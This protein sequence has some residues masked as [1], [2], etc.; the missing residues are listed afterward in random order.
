MYIGKI[1]GTK[2]KLN[3]LF[4]CLMLFMFIFGMAIDSILIFV[5][6][7]VH[8]LGHVIVA[9]KMKYQ[10]E[11]IELLPIGGVATISDA[12]YK[13]A[14]DEWF[15]AWAGPFNNLLF[16]VILT[17]YKESTPYSDILIQ[18]NLTLFFFNLLPALPL[19]GGRIIKATLS[20]NRS[21]VEANKIAALFG[22]FIGL[23]MIGLS[24]YY[25]M[26][27]LNSPVYLFIL[28]LFLSISAFKEYKNSTYLPVRIGFA[29]ATNNNR[30]IEGKLVICPLHT[31]IRDVI[32]ELETNRD[33]II[34]VVDQKGEI[35]D[36]L[37]EKIV[38]DKYN[39][40]HG[41]K[42]LKQLLM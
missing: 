29:K 5:V 18:Y 40:G 23:L 33:L 35:V 30:I 39:K 4:L 24:G 11:S 13:S 22:I 26:T 32:K 42:T 9:K 36:M 6:V 15:I 1:G 20:K 14:S 27:R 19:D 17:F 25:Y 31:P 37:T 12:H 8:E 38:V 34:F 3:N 7:I 41:S 16:I 21:Y 28:G 10:V 2:L